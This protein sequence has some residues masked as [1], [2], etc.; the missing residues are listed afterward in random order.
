VSALVRAGLAVVGGG[1]LRLTAEGMDVHSAV[2]ERLF[3]E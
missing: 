3:G 1:R 2:A